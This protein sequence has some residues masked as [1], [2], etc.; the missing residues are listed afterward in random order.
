MKMVAG[1]KLVMRIL[2]ECKIEVLA[3]TDSSVFS[4]G[5]REKNNSKKE[6]KVQFAAVDSY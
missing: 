6:T 5:S 4:I 2:R 1:E 3:T